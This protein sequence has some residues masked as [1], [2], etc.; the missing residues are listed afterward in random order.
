VSYVELRPHNVRPVRVLAEGQWW[1]GVLE[2]FER[3]DGSWRGHVR[4]SET[5]GGVR[6]G[7]F[8]ASELSLLP[9]QTLQ[10]R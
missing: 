2:A 3:R 8:A 6:I 7:W 4:W 10:A 9:R 1:A 5:R